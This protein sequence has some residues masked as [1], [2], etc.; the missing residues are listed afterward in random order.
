MNLVPQPNKSSGLNQR[1]GTSSTKV[2]NKQTTQHK[3]FPAA[4]NVQGKECLVIGDD[5]EASE[6]SERLRES[7]AHVV[8]VTPQ[9]FS[10]DLLGSQF[11]VIFCVKTNPALTKKIADVCHQ[12]RILLCAIDQPSYCDV[13]NVSVFDKGRLRVAIGTGGAAPAISRKIRIGLEESLKDV[14]LDEYLDYLAALR[15]KLEHEIPDSKKRI[16]KL[17]EAT[18]GFEFNAS[19][20]FPT[21]W[22]TK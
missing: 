14:P 22:R 7:G 11:L 10:L 9:E 8:V 4:L 18:D 19:V 3:Y 15:E 5:R 20:R 17:I 21:T 6:K 12:K 2:S 16:P 1:I 13:V